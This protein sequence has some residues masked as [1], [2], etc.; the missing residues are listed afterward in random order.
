MKS[1]RNFNFRHLFQIISVSIFI[2]LLT[3]FAFAQS[4]QGRIVGTVTDANGAV[5][6]G[7]IVNVKNEKT[8]ETRT[9]TA[10]ADGTFSVVALQPTTY[11]VT[12][13]G[14]SF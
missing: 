10:T 9:V 11:T 7:A 8:G 1:L 5:V 12:A 4:E 6:P 3:T 14:G 13:N 2:T